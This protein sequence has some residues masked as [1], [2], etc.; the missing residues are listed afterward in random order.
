[1][2]TLALLLF[3]TGWLAALFFAVFPLLPAPLFLWLGA[4]LHEALTGFHQLGGWDWAW[5]L[6][7]GVLSLILDNLAAVWSIRRYGGSHLAI[8]AALGAGL[9]LTLWLG[10]L[11]LL[12]GAVLGPLLV[13]LARGRGVKRALYATWGSL[14]GL[15]AGSGLRLV[16]QLGLGLWLLTKFL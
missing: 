3:F 1:M 10:P 2:A 9:L 5:L 12:L 15:L 16:L 6:L 14:L 4:F 7:L 13:E 11:G 8:L